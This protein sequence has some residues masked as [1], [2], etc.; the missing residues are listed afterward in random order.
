[1]IR[2]DAVSCALAVVQI[3]MGEMS[4][5]ETIHFDSDAV[6]RRRPGGRVALL[7]AVHIDGQSSRTRA[8]LQNRTC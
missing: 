3:V 2:V 5:A 6:A 4:M 7:A 8:L 1:M